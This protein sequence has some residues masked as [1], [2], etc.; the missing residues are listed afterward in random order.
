MSGT[1]AISMSLSRFAILLAAGMVPLLPPGT[2]S[3]P[4]DQAAVLVTSSKELQRAFRLRRT[5]VLQA[6]RTYSVTP[7]LIV[8]GVL[9]CQGATIEAASAGTRGPDDPTSTLLE[10]DDSVLIDG[11]LDCRGLVNS[12]V[13]SRGRLRAIGLTIV[14]YRRKGL[15]CVHGKDGKSVD[16]ILVDGLTVRS[17][18]LDPKR[19]GPAFQYDSS[20]PCRSVILRGLAAGA[21]NDIGKPPSVFKVA[22]VQRLYADE[23]DAGGRKIVFGENVGEAFIQVKNLYYGKGGRGIDYHPDPSW[24]GPPRP[25][26]LTLVEQGW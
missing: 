12:G 21:H 14:D 13:F 24:K 25:A 6:G 26:R 23:I 16:S 9:L 22:H 8:R 11:T 4:A 2:T 1:R 10:C 18:K 17:R 5:V 3:R 15:H 19:T 7:P 20:Q